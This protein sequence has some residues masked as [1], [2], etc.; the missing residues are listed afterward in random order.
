MQVTMRIPND[1]IGRVIG[2]E[3]TT[4]NKIRQVLD[5]VLLMG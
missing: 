1:K 5:S 3:G 2:K 4:I